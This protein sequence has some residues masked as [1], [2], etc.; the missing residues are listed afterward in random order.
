MENNKKTYNERLIEEL[1][2]EHNKLRQNPESFI[3]PLKKVLNLIRRNNILHFQNERPY[4]TL[5]GK[6]A[7]LEAINYITNIPNS[8]KEKLSHRLFVVS[9]YLN[10]ACLEHAEDIGFSGSYSH[11]GSDK[12]HLNDRV[13]KYCYWSG[14]LAESLDFGTNQ[15]QNI[16]LKLLICD[17]DKKRTQRNYLFDPGFIYF[18]AGFSKHIKYRRCAVISYAALVRDKEIELTE[19]ELIQNCLDIYKNFENKNIKEITNYFNNNNTKNL[20]KKEE[21]INEKDKDEI[22]KKKEEEDENDNNDEE[23]NLRF[24]NEIVTN[25]NN[26]VKKKKMSIIEEED[27]EKEENIN[28]IKDNTNQIKKIKEREIKRYG[29]KIK[30][31]TYQIKEGNFHI[32]EE[33]TA[34]SN[35]GFLKLI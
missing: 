4:R 15:A 19:K 16:M 29:I 25:E 28:Q 8:L 23:K 14:G 26:N 32:V 9:E 3:E 34:F 18:G 33:E 1:F 31:T 2:N 22:N 35:F 10:R 5:E 6:D 11:I 20:E 24:D 27:N 17:G 30:E 7:V 13:E 12:S 21:I